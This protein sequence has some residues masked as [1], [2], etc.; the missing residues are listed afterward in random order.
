MG[1]TRSFCVAARSAGPR[2]GSHSGRIPRG[3]SPSAPA[4]SNCAPDSKQR[5][6]TTE[7]FE[8]QLPT[9]HHNIQ[10]DQFWYQLRN[11]LQPFAA[12]RGNPH[13]ELVIVQQIAGAFASKRIILYTKI[14]A[15]AASVMIIWVYTSPHSPAAGSNF[16][17]PTVR[18]RPSQCSANA[19]SARPVSTRCARRSAV[20]KR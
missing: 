18:R 19:E 8:S 17:W 15:S 10:A 2:R 9:Q 12:S 3:I 6:L 20:P 16:P 5:G 11:R 13:V 7:F 14:R 1:H 4:G